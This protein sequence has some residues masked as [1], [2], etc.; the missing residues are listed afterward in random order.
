MKKLALT[1]AT[2]LAA[3]AIA[4]PAIA[5]GNGKPTA[6][7]T[8]SA[9]ASTSAS[10]TG[11]AKRMEITVN[12]VV[13][14]VATAALGPVKIKLK[15]LPQGKNKLASK[16]KKGDEMTILV[17]ANS[18]V[19]RNGVVAPLTALVTN[20]KVTAKIVSVDSATGIQYTAQMVSATG[21]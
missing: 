3:T 14:V 13:T 19:K 5:A 16:L 20:D 18:V 1:I 4:A 7:P 11:A 17:T 10:A 12:G 8:P 21:A 6:K 9:S 2:A 15:T